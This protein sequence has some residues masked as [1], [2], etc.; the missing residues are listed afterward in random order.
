MSRALDLLDPQNEV[1]PYQYFTGKT[2]NR[3]ALKRGYKNL[4]AGVTEILRR[5]DPVGVGPDA[6]PSEYRPEATT[7]LPRLAR[8]ASSADVQ[9]IV[10]EELVRWFDSSSVG[11]EHSLTGIA[12]EIWALSQ[13]GAD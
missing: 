1:P 10:Y 13:Q 11:G 4:L 9:R 7:I 8:A 5:H 3:R 6:P 2:I 12:D